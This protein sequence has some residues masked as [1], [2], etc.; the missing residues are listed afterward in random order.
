M[1]SLKMVPG[2]PISLTAQFTGLPP[3]DQVK[4]IAEPA[5]FCHNKI[6]CLRIDTHAD[7]K[8]MQNAIDSYGFRYC[9]IYHVADGTPRNAYD[10]V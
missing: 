7:N 5:C 2:T 8:P 9:G 10:L 1:P 3:T 4:G 6:D